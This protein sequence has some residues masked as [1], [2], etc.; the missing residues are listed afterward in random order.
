MNK[1]ILFLAS[2]DISK[3]VPMYIQDF[4][5]RDCI[6]RS[7]CIAGMFT[8]WDVVA[9]L[10]KRIGLDI[11]RNVKAR[12]NKLEKRIMSIVNEFEPDIVCAI[13]GMMFN[14]HCAEKIREQ[15]F[16]AIRMIDRFSFFPE[17]YEE[18]FSDHYDAIYTYSL[19]DY[20]LINS[21]SQNCV[22]IPAMPEEEVY[23]NDYLYRDI[24]ISFVG[25]MYPEKDYGNRYVILCHLI[26]DFP[27]LNI[28][29]GG[30]CAPIR[31]PKKWFEW[32]RN[33]LYRKA[34][35]NKQITATECNNIYNRTKISINMERN[36]TGNSWSGR[37][38]NLF[39]T[40]N[41]VLSADNSKMLNKYFNGCFVPFSDY[42]DLKEKIFYYLNHEKERNEI[43]MRA[44]RRIEKLKNDPNMVNMA[45]DIL[46]READ[47]REV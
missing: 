13:N 17:Y 34:F 28:F 10:K 1:K 40:G 27:D 45:D 47:R 35:N 26:R 15:A 18:G 30:E 19:D 16:L 8:K 9:R 3:G 41:F 44:Y 5:E 6:V 42:A 46:K 37:L 25:K 11:R 22:F 38:V 2:M 33:P 36:G 23:H 31:R 21:R 32:N 43:A 14:S 4:I 20:E 29:V 12:Q 39:S 7:C 24:D